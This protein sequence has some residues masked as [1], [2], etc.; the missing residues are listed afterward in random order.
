MT[1]HFLIAILLLTACVDG[2]NDQFVKSDFFEIAK[3]DYHGKLLQRIFVV[4]L[5]ENV[6]DTS[7]IRQTICEL[8]KSYPLDNNSN[9]SFFSDK[10]YAD[11]KTE[12]FMDGKN[13]LPQT[14]YKSWMDSYYLGEYEFKTNQYNTYPV[15]STKE[16]QKSYR[17]NCCP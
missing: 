7:V 13:L 17:L 5:S 9:I 8:K 12:L 15:S 16:K 3:I 2:N 1:R 6:N 10:K 11:Y 14:E 4:I